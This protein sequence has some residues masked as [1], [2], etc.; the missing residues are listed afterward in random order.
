M[1]LH[2]KNV[3]LTGASGGIGQAL[4]L[5]LAEKGARLWLVGR[6]AAALT[7]LCERLPH[8]AHH[9]IVVV[10][11]YSDEEI[12]QLSETFWGSSRLDVLINNA[13]TSRFA[14]FGEQSYSDIREQIRTNVE[15][16]LLLTRALARQF[17]A[18]GIILNVGSILGEIGHPGYSVYSATKAA[19]HRFSE[20]L[21]RELCASG[22]SVLYV[23]PRAT[24][25]DFNSASANALNDSLK[26]GV[27]T[28]EFVAGKIVRALE[29]RRKRLRF[30]FAERLFV[31]IN[32]L[33]PAL[34]DNAL[35]RK[36]SV[37]HHFARQSAK[38]SVK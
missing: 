25:T 14:L 24:R 20:A 18:D 17:N 28:P 36:M 26:N 4:A 32:A 19:L 23:A 35:T 12:Q 31:K 8:R 9:R 16:P 5:T 13:G 11:N 15:L 7:A 33:F 3:L 37:I 27:D 6:N 1:N 2:N 22:L 21:G 34:V 30:G 38:G 29:K 10:Q